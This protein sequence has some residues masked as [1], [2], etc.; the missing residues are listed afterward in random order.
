MLTLRPNLSEGPL[1]SQPRQQDRLRRVG[2]RSESPNLPSMKRPDRTRIMHRPWKPINK[3]A[4][5]QGREQVSGSSEPILTCENVP[6][7]KCAIN[8]HMRPWTPME[9]HTTNVASTR[10]VSNALKMSTNATKM[11]HFQ[12]YA[13][14]QCCILPHFCPP[15]FSR[16]EPHV[17]E[18][19]IFVRRRPCVCD[20]CLGCLGCLGC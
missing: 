12:L 18:W 7:T 2:Q 10:E 3:N 14:T 13:R 9:N 11:M 1:R 16:V 15:T 4:E 20:G 6:C 8:A 5:E 17:Q 19:V